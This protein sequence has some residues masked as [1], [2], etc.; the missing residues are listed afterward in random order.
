[1]KTL[2]LLIVLG[3]LPMLALGAGA[4]PQGHAGHGGGQTGDHGAHGAPAA[5]HE[6]GRAHAD[7]AQGGPQSRPSWG[8]PGDPAQVTRTVDIEMSDDM[9]FTPAEVRVKQGETVRF[10]GRN[11]G[12]MKHEMVIGPLEVLQAH[13]AEMRAMPHMAHDDPNAIQLD[14]R[15]MGAIVWRFDQPGEIDFACLLPGHLEAGMAGR[16]TIR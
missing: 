15:Q 16:I 7:H 1:M 5:N 6:P 10:F 12:A 11:R 3:S 4:H 14:P 13:A 8:L 9:R 2:A